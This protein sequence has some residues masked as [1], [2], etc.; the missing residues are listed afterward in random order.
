MTDAISRI[1]LD[2]AISRFASQSKPHDFFV[3]ALGSTVVQAMHEEEGN[4]VVVDYPHVDQ[5]DAEVLEMEAVLAMHGE[6]YRKP[7]SRDEDSSVVYFTPHDSGSIPACVWAAIDHAHARTG[8]D[9]VLENGEGAHMPP[10][11]VRRG[12]LSGGWKSIFGG[13]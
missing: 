7:I 1:D 13:D 4:C 8:L 10:K 5:S 11:P 12:F 3:I 6:L 9:P 2:I